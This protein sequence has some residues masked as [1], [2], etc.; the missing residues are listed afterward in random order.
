MSNLLNRLL[1][2]HFLVLT[3]GS[4]EVYGQQNNSNEPAPKEY[5]ENIF[6][7][8]LLINSQT[9]TTLHA[10]SWSFGL[11]HRFGQ[12][13]LDSTMIQQLLG[14]DLPAAIR[15]SFGRAFSDRFYIEVGRTNHL[16]TF[17]LEAKYLITKQTTDF[18]MPVSIAAYFNTAI[19]TEKFPE[20]PDDVFYEDGTT[21]FEYKFSHRFAY[22]TQL[23]ISSKLSDKISLQINPIFIFENLAKPYHDNLTGVL[24]AGGRYKI[25]LSSALIAEYA[26]VVNNRNDNF[27]N[28]FSFG[29][30]FGTVGHT[31]Q[32]FVTTA[33][34]V[35][36][37]HI[38][39]SS[40]VNISEGDFLLGFNLKRVFWRKAKS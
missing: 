7:G 31:F 39:T 34:K 22:N 27:H 25:G 36:E 16:K 14:L 29:V 3:L 8:T 23:I 2:V 10:K 30:E 33:T 38:Y 20:L 11:Q 32:V 18:K 40:A 6:T 24:S 17:D 12:V 9:T 37:S 21:P 35:L 1:T 5:A 28:P 4:T 15:F 13:S 26:Y 19:R